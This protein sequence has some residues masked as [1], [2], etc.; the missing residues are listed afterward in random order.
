MAS[1]A[2]EVRFTGKMGKA[3][4]LKGEGDKAY[5]TFGIAVDKWVGEGKGDNDKDGKPTSYKTTWIDVTAF[6]RTAQFIC[7]RFSPG[8]TMVV[9]GELDKKTYEKKDKEGNVI[10]KYAV[11]VR[12]LLRDFKGPYRSVA[13]SD[14]ANGNGNSTGNGHQGQARSQSA[15]APARQ[16]NTRSAAPAPKNNR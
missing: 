10:D 1:E 14:K 13:K 12:V 7:D 15:P 11:S 9:V 8:D 16:S 5:T 2:I 3:P 6:G 4:E